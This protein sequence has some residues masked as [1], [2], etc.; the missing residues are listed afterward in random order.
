MKYGLAIF[1]LSI[2]MFSCKQDVS[3][4]Y[5]RLDL[6]Q[7][8][9]PI[10][11]YA[12]ADAEVVKGDLGVM[13]DVTIKSGEEFYIQVFASDATTVDVKGILSDMI[14]EVKKTPF[15]SKIVEEYED[16]FIYENKIDDR[17]NYDFRYIKLQADK[18]Y[19]FQ[20]GFTGKYT[21]EQVKDM[22]AAVQQ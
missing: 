13:Q 7:Y 14:S 11:I 16:G 6:L 3:S 5:P 22:Y 4:K 20:T 17:I 19:V 9:M 8:G 10:E 1:L 15:F 21:E 12:P 18:E 2:L